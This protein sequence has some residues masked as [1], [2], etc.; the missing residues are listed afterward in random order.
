[1]NKITTFC[2]KYF[3]EIITIVSFS[4]LTLSVILQIFFD[5]RA[6]ELCVVQR[7]EYTLLLIFGLGEMFLKRHFFKSAGRLKVLAASILGLGTAVYTLWV[8][9]PSALLLEI[10]ENCVAP[11][12]LLAGVLAFFGD[13]SPTLYAVRG[14]CFDE[15]TRIFGIGMPTISFFIFLGLVIF[16]IWVIIQERKGSY[17]QLGN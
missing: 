11:D 3:F 13:I 1:M 12:S 2:K 5:L 4:V 8:T 6:C 9:R 17:D 15:P 7:L 10:P 14:S 16:S